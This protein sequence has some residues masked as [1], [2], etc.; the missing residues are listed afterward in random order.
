MEKY[1]IV[2]EKDEIIQ[3][4]DTKKGYSSL[5]KNGVTVIAEDD[6]I[7]KLFKQDIQ[8]LL[9]NAIEI[10]PVKKWVLLKD[11]PIEKA[12][13]VIIERDGDYVIE[14][15][16]NSFPYAPF[17]EGWF[18]E[19]NVKGIIDEFS[20]GEAIRVSFLQHGRDSWISIARDVKKQLN[21]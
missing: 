16:G 4:L 7:E 13:A 19:V 6:I 17:Q 18:R 20:L 15:S 2:A 5:T 21:V 3:H 8:K 9:K 12:G 11:L 10:M 1:L 14:D